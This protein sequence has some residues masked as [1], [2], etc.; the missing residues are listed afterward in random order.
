MLH[1]YE[2]V[3]EGKERREKKEERREKK[4]GS[5]ELTRANSSHEGAGLGVEWE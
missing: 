4:E 3:E 5:A 2:R 1:Q